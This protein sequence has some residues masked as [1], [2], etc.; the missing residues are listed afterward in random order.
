MAR[1]SLTAGL[2]S[3]TQSFGQIWL[4]ASHFNK[5]LLIFI[6]GL[7]LFFSWTHTLFNKVRTLLWAFNYVGQTLTKIGG[8][9]QSQELFV[10]H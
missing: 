4:L 7:T 1:I 8:N 5:K 10:L 2:E 3:V 6:H 9:K